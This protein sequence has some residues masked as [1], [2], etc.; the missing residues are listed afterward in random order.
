VRASSTA[1]RVHAVSD[2]LRI[3]IGRHI[4]RVPGWIWRGGL[5]RQARM[6]KR[7]LAFMTAEH[8]RV[9]DAVVAELARSR[10]PVAPESIAAATGVDLVRTMEILDLLEGKPMFLV[11]DDRGRIEWAYPI[12]AAETPH[13]VSVDSEEPLYAA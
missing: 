9:R 8:H 4:V 3:G 12:T 1:R 2:A 10:A 11:R 5:K 7:S 6:V 13:R